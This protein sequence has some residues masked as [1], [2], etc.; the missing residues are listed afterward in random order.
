M[1]H[2]VYKNKNTRSTRI[3]LHVQYTQSLNAV[4]SGKVSDIY[5]QSANI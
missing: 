2:T 4:S 1:G 5:K 3:K